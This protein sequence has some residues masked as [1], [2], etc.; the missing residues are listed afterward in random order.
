M[1]DKE[2]VVKLERQLADATTDIK[3]L[4]EQNE[5]LWGEVE[6]AEKD[7]QALGVAY[8]LLGQ[9]YDDLYREYNEL[10]N[11]D[12]RTAHEIIDKI[13]ELIGNGITAGDFKRIADMLSTEYS[14]KGPIY[15]L[16]Y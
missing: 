16:D 3:I 12:N 8:E 5:K 7:N 11:G 14:I 13:H 1:T 10:A 2:R 15:G 4:E 9:D 6:D